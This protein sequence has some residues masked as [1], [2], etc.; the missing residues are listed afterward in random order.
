MTRHVLRVLWPSFLMAGVL[1]GLVFSVIDPHELHWFAGPLI[2][3]DAMSIYSVS[4]LL[5]WAV[6]SMS[7]VVTALLYVEQDGPAG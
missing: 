1:E 6:V 7:G 5:F 2:G 3:W 4:F